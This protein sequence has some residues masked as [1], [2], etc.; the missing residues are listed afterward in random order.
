MNQL[1][2]NIILLGNPKAAEPGGGG[3]NGLSYFSGQNRQYTGIGYL[4]RLCPPPLFYQCA[5]LTTK[6]DGS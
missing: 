2:F 5:C 4:D 1:G 6:I 3:I